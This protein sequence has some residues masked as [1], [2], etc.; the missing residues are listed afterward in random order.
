MELSKDQ[1]RFLVALDEEMERQTA[2]MLDEMAEA[3]VS[4]LRESE[5]HGD[6]LE[7][8]DR[9]LTLDESIVSKLEFIIS[10][11]FIERNLHK[12]EGGRYAN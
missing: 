4:A 2:K 3:I 12:I 6:F 11:S 10:T 8:V 7:L 1:E 9:M 5:E